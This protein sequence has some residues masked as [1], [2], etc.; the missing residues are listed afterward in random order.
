[1]EAQPRLLSRA[2]A[3]PLACAACTVA[4]AVSIAIDVPGGDGE[5]GLIPC[6]VRALTGSW[7]PG[8]GL[9]RATHHL[10]RGNVSEA[11][12][13]HLFVPFVLVALAAAWWVWLRVSLGRGVPAFVVAIQVRSYVVAGLVLAAFTL[14][15]NVEGF[16]MLRGG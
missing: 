8:C 10:L 7:C 13:F 12:S 9:T 3:L 16:D 4:A 5:G 6:P 11:L 15:R 1:M 2:A 14:A